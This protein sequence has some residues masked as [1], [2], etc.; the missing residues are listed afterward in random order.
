MRKALWAVQQWDKKWLM[1][2]RRKI[3]LRAAYQR[4]VQ[5]DALND[6][7]KEDLLTKLLV[8][9]DDAQSEVALDDVDVKFNLHFPADDVE[10]EQ[11]QFKRPK[12]RSLYSVCRKAGLGNVTKYFG[13]SPEQFGENLQAMYK[14]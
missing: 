5:G 3:T 10:A 14:V 6:T 9:L 4:R 1:L 7:A 2:R 13:L 8:A 12:R 11:G